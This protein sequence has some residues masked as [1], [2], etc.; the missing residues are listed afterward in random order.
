MIRGIVTFVV[1]FFVITFLITLLGGWAGTAEVVL[2]ALAA[3]LLA[4]GD[5]RLRA[6][7]KAVS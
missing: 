7:R 4:V 2:L 1:V 3:A 6:H 5:N